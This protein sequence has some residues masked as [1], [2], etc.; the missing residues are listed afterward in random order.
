MKRSKILIPAGAFALML[1]IGGACKKS[2]LD[3][4]IITA[5]NTQDYNNTNR[6]RRPGNGHVSKPPLSF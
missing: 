5:K 6:V 1:A 2:F 3:E 4:T